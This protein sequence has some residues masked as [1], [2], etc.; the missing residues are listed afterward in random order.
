MDSK[1]KISLYRF[2]YSGKL[3][4]AALESGEKYGFGP[5]EVVRGGDYCKLVNSII[6]NCPGDYALVSR[7]KVFWPIGIASAVDAAIDSANE[8]FGPAR[9]GVIGNSGIEF[10]SHRKIEYLQ[11]RS[12]K[13]I[14]SCSGKPRPVTAL[15]GN[16]L[17]LNI[18]NLRDRSVRI[19]DGLRGYSIPGLVLV[20]ECYKKALVSA[21]DSALYVFDQTD[22]D[23]YSYKAESTKSRFRKYWSSSFVNKSMDTVYGTIK[24]ENSIEHLKKNSGDTRLD[25]YAL[26]ASVIKDIYRSRPK[27]LVN[28]VARTR[29]ERPNQLRRLL[30]TVRMAR[31]Y[32]LDMLDL[33][34]V[35]AANNLSSSSPDS[36]LDP[37]LSEYPDLDFIVSRDNPSSGMYP[38]VSAIKN[39][40]EWMEDDSFVWFVDD[41]DFIYPESLPC[42][43]P[44]LSAKTIFVGDS[45]IFEE[46]WSGDETIPIKS[47]KSGLYKSDNYQD[48]VLGENP[49][50]FCSVIYPAAVLKNICSNFSLTGDYC[51]DYALFLI[52]S[53]SATVV[54][55][56]LLI[57][58]VSRHSGTT[59]SQKDRTHWNYSYASFISEIVRKGVFPSWAFDHL[60]K[61]TPKKQKLSFSRRLKHFLRRISGSINTKSRSS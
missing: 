58:G 49:I 10:I 30:D 16:T 45:A 25:Y 7:G 18:R 60:R 32:S 17:L 42:L 46:E 29:L 51:E 33:K 47:R 9:W 44:F 53:S 21:L 50:P 14:P 15:D 2:V 43:P 56:P 52:A 35:V 4:S 61:R 24:L 12:S 57:A 27:P 37:I 23:E 22:V 3:K 54:N 20:M 8:E 40:L 28:I 38:R 26:V 6:E 55:V 5:V 39:A 13:I 41:D 31:S 34:V 11:T 36:T 1:Y 59:V 48:C 19:P